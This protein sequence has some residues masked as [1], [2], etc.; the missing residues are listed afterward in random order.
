MGNFQLE[1]NAENQLAY[2]LYSL[3]PE[4]VNRLLASLHPDMTRS[5]HCNALREELVAELHKVKIVQDSLG[6]TV[7]W[8][9]LY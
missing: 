4:E 7:D 8:S 5:D 3:S 1:P 9:V 6:L 2:L